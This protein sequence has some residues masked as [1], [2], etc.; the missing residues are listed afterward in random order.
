LA[1]RIGVSPG[2]LSQLLEKL[3]Q[4]IVGFFGAEN[5]PAC[6]AA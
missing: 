5:L 1:R 3:G 4:E 6:C 2:R